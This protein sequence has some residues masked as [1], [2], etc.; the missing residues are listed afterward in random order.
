MNVD[1]FARQMQALNLRLNKLYQGANASPSPPIEHLLPVAFK[2]LGIVSEELQ[3][4]VEELCQ[5]NEELAV[6]Q[7][8][9]QA[10]RQRYQD[11]FELAPE[12]YLV[13]DAAGK[14]REAN[15]A[16]ALLLNI[17]E[18][19]LIGK[20]LVVFVAS[21]ER[22]NFRNELNRQQTNSRIQD[23]KVRLQPRGGEPFEA[24]L[25]VSV[26]RDREGMPLS[27]R[28]I[29]RQIGTSAPIK[30]AHQTNN[31]TKSVDRPV[32][33]YAKGENI[34]LNPQVIWQVERGLVKLTT[35]CDTGEEVLV[36]LVGDQMLFGS[37]LTALKTYQA[38]AMSKQVQL[39]EISLA[40]I[41]NNPHLSQT[42]FDQINRRLKQTE[43]LLAIFAKRRV[44]DRLQHLLLLLKQEIGEPHREGTRLKVRLTHEDFANT[45]CTTRVTM[46]RLLLGL[47]QEGKIVFDCDR[48]LILKH[49]CF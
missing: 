40:E 19:H 28:W 18:Q 38:T 10:E 26:V 14:I 36:G 21:E 6:V 24:M 37:S 42:F 23:W 34:P 30:I 35:I 16:A 39:V 32:E 8:E 15:R 46:T 44:Q 9:L 7:L 2:E 22:W 25:T 1:I 13:T 43:L 48:H 5:Q 3:V 12:A 29:L 17:S 49:G 4:A 33:V 31:D 27:L 47:Q 45:C 41:A 20:P 11:L